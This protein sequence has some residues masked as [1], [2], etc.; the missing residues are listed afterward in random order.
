MFYRF[1]LGTISGTAADMITEAFA[2]ERNSISSCGWAKLT[3]A[4]TAAEF[5]YNHEK[6]S[7]YAKIPDV[8]ARCIVAEV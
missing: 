4:V 8:K 2:L 1:R 7:V 3:V 5:S 6:E